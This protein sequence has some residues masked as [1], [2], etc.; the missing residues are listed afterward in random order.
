MAGSPLEV[1]V[2]EGASLHANLD[3]AGQ[4]DA[5]TS[6]P[7]NESDPPSK[8]L[9]ILALVVGVLGLLTGVAA[10]ATRRKTPAGV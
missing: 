1:G 4:S 6:N 7:T 5:A 10:L 8:D 2:G 9:V 3:G